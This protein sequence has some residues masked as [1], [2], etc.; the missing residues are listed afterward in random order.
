MRGMPY[1]PNGL[2]YRIYSNGN[3]RWTLIFWE[4]C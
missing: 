2:S 1:L 3:G 4:N